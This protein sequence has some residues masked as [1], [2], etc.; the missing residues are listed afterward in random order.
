MSNESFDVESGLSDVGV[1]R[2]HAGHLAHQL[3]PVDVHIRV[4][5]HQTLNKYS[6]LL[7]QTLD[8]V[9]LLVN[10]LPENR[11]LKQVVGYLHQLR[12]KLLQQ[13]K[14]F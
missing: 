5:G 4:V 8:K 12:L 3:L 9:L 7:V 11:I 2:L 10:E 6:L 1:V 13:T 14:T